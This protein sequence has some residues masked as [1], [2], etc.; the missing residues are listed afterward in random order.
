MSPRV[1]ISNLLPACSGDIEPMLIIAQAALESG[2]GK[3]CIGK[4]NYFGIKRGSWQGKVIMVRTRE[5]FK[6]RNAKLP[7]GD[8]VL[9]INKRPDGRYDYV[10]MCAFRDYSSLDEA[11]KDHEQVLKRLVPDK[12][13]WCDRVEMARSLVGKYATDP[14]YD[15]KLIAMFKYIDK[16]K[17]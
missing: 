12:N 8:K 10:C 7:D 14:L 16:I 13:I 2:W 4:Y 17:K 6:T 5:V 1:F 3:H 11:L 9:S 15:E